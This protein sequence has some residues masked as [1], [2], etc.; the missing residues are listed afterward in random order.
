MA[1]GVSVAVAA[2]IYSQASTTTTH[3]VTSSSGLAECN[4]IDTANH[5]KQKVRTQP[6][7]NQNYYLKTVN[8]RHQ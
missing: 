4:P 2:Q 6:T 5:C 8:P 3:Y 7:P 1:L